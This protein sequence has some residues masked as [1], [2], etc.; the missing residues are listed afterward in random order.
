MSPRPCFVSSV[1]DLAKTVRWCRTAECPLPGLKQTC[2]FAPHMSA[3]GPKQTSAAAPHMSA[4]G[5]KADITFRGNPLSPGTFEPLRSCPEPQ[6][7]TMRR[8]E[9]ITLLGGA[10][11]SWPLATRAQ[12]PALP[13][14][15][16][17]RDG[18]ADPNSRYAA[19]FRK[20]L[21]ETGYV[22]GQNV[23]V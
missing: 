1:S 19:A 2:R 9:F 8:R 5:G 4:F 10:A 23:T 22:E 20:G 12:Q 14:V 11:A 7:A 17:V 13:V 21:N 15:G 18:S 3:I 6:G 16:F